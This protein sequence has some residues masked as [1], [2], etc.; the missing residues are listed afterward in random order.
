[1]VQPLV[2]KPQH[3]VP[4]TRLPRGFLAVKPVE[5]VSSSPQDIGEYP[6]SWTSVYPAFSK[7]RRE[8]LSSVQ[9]AK[10]QTAIAMNFFMLS[11]LVVG[12][13]S[14]LAFVLTIVAENP[15]IYHRNERPPNAT[16]YQ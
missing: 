5:N 12:E 6:V 1:M 14:P 3:T 10:R 7:V 15:L 4:E 13:K 16:R 11:R 2:K 8:L 9:P